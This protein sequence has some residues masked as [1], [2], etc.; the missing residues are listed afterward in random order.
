MTLKTVPPKRSTR[1]FSSRKGPSIMLVMTP[2]R[3]ASRPLNPHPGRAGAPSRNTRLCCADPMSSRTSGSPGRRAFNPME[4]AP[5]PRSAGSPSRRMRSFSTVPRRSWWFSTGP[6][7]HF[8]I[9]LLNEAGRSLTTPKLTRTAACRTRNVT[10]GRRTAKDPMTGIM[11]RIEAGV[12]GV[13]REKRGIHRKRL[14]Q[15]LRGADRHPVEAA[16]I[17]RK[18]LIL[19]RLGLFSGLVRST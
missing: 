3:D 18:T 19:G 14:I 6:R 17:R 1:Q 7:E 5:G 11:P 15:G 2:S 4:L 16:A 12:R 8:G 10:L 13:Y 9:G